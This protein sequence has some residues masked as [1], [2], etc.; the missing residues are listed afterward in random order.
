M[1]STF[2][3]IDALFNWGQEMYLARRFAEVDAVL[4]RVNIEKLD[5]ALIHA[6]LVVA[7]WP[8]NV[9]EGNL[10]PSRTVLH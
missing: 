2:K 1:A 9:G 7:W 4:A 5:D 3:K 10:I 8:E 6:W